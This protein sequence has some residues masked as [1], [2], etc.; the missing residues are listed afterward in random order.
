LEIITED[1]MQPIE[2]TP[3]LSEMVG[4][5]L[6]PSALGM[7]LPDL[8]KVTVDSDQLKAFLS[9]PQAPK[10]SLGEA[11]DLIANIPDLALKL[12]IQQNGNWKDYFTLHLKA[13][14]SLGVSAKAGKVNILPKISGL[15]SWGDWAP[16]YQPQDATFLHES[17]EETVQ[18][19]IGL[20]SGEGSEGLALDVPVLDLGY[21]NLSIEHVRVAKP[22]FLLDLVKVVKP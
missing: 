1:G 5:I 10:L 13:D 2:L 17:F 20:M 8:Q 4:E 12:Q 3:D 9:L 22:Y 7:F 18:T 21:G 14:L 16:G 19:I 15:K 11:G 6:K